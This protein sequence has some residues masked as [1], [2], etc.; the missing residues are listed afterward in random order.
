MGVCPVRRVTSRVLLLGAVAV[1][2]AT[3]GSAV[4]VSPALAGGVD[5]GNQGLLS[6][7]IYNVTPYTWTL[8][9]AQSPTNGPSSNSNN[10]KRL[11]SPGK[12]PGCWDTL[13]DS[14]I[15]PGKGT[16]YRLRPWSDEGTN[17]IGPDRYG[18]DAYITY[19]VN[20][21]GGPPEYA[22]V[23]IWGKW[24]QNY[25]FGGSTDP[26]FSV[27]FTAAP[28]SSKYDAWNS[29]GAAPSAQIGKPQLT[30]Q[31][32]VPYLYDQSFQ[33]A[34]NYTV[35]ASTDLG[36]PFVDVLN[37]MCGGAT[38]TTCSFTQTGPLKWGIGSLSSPQQATDCAAPGT[39]PGYITMGYEASQSASLSVGGGVST[40]VEVNLFNTIAS[41]ATIS[42]E[43]EHEWEETKTLDR[44]TKVFIPPREIASVWV[45][46]VVGKVTGTLVV[47]NGSATFTATNFSEERSGVTKDPLTPAYDVI[48]KVRPMTAGELA[49]HCHIGARI[50]VGASSSEPPNRLTPGQG[51]ARVALGQTQ[52]QVAAELGRPLAKH[53]RVDPCRELQRG[54]Y[55]EDATGGTW[56]YRRLSV[57][58]GPDLRV[59]GLIYSGPQRS[60]KHIGVGSTLAAVRRA[61]PRIACSKPTPRRI[62]C[63]LTSVNGPWAVKTVFQMS[64]RRSGGRF[65][66]GQ[67]LIYVIHHRR[68]KVSA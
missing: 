41:E 53:F 39:E 7:A 67:V 51:V 63:A 43:A 26:N 32:N 42:V 40:S 16:I 4:F 54:C 44:E 27:F 18:F 14:T 11:E 55:A 50:G 13:P 58:F 2:C 56:A 62:D 17:C 49:D 28:P 68:G 66:T 60:Q 45:V 33:I 12:G 52:A 59:S 19:R 5:G 36:A 29:G 6:A 65:K 15:N 21:V 8:V 9:A 24:T 3:A 57:V 46:P 64:R 38:N 25:C 37:A 31:H 10:C 34:G 47:S 20:V 30:Y 35:D 1:V 61:M 22:T 23:V 48:T